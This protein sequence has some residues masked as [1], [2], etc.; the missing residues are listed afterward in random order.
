MDSNVSQN[1]LMEIV[2]SKAIIDRSLTLGKNTN[3]QRSRD[4]ASLNDTA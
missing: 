1:S 2:K 4:N 3:M